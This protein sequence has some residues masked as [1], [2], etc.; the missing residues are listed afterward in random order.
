[1]KWRK[2]VSAITD[3]AKRYRANRVRPYGAKRCAYSHRSNPC[4]GPLG[5]NH[6]DGDES[7]GKRSNLN[8]ACKRHNAQL[9]V[10]HKAK[11]KGVRT[12]Q[13]NPGA[14]NLAQYVQAAVEHTRGAHDAGG[15][16]IHETPKATRKKF[17]REIA[18]RKG[19]RNPATSDDLYKKFHGRRG[20][21]VFLQVEDA[22]FNS[23]KD[24]AALG[25]LISLTVGEGVKLTGKFLDQPEA[26]EDDAWAVKLEF[27]LNAPV[28]AAQP[29]GSQMFFVG[30]NQD[31]S[32]YL[33][34]FPVDTSKELIP[35]GP[36]IRIEYHTEK[37]FD[38][39]QPVNYFH[40]L[41][42]ESGEYPG[43]NGANP[44]LLYNRI[45]RKLYLVGGSY[46]VKP[47]GIVD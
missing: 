41:G 47:E 45:R 16:V 34:K 42:E 24:L 14:T 20:K 12:R 35:L 37:R 17:A 8:W 5:V 9:A 4:K 22:D 25:K 15:R 19:Y 33:A 44:I 11:G 40:A 28:V 31:I 36:C 29:E 27:P 46:H 43:E 39:F 2:P 6:I 23:H 26:F 13:Y 1:M 32:R 30:G 3:R 18:F 38:R 10:Y 7:N 21:D